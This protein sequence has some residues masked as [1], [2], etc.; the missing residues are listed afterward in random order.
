MSPPDT[1]DHGQRLGELLAWNA[2]L[3]DAARQ[4]LNASP[5]LPAL[6]RWQ[7]ERLARSYADLRAAPRYSLA[8]EFFLSDLYGDRDVSER[9]ANVERILPLMRRWL[10]NAVLGTVALAVELHALSH[11]LDLAVV[12][13]LQK[14]GDEPVIDLERYGQAYRAAGRRHDRRRQIHLIGALGRELDV[15]VRKPMVA[16]TLRLARGPAR[17]AGLAELQSF[18]ERGFTAFSAIGGAE[19]FLS[20]I[21]Q[22]ELTYMKRLQAGRRDPFDFARRS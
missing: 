18:L 9:D 1:V 17:L 4:P 5:W 14:Y 8:A 7:A 15:W 16:R 12:A 22:R 11:E 10:P 2:A 19:E 21:E 6:Q 13:E 3:R 20:L